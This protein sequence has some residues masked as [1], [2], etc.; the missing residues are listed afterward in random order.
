MH[1]HSALPQHQLPSEADQYIQAHLRHASCVKFTLRQLRQATPVSTHLQ[2]TPQSKKGKGRSW[3]T[4]AVH[5]LRHDANSTNT[6]TCRQAALS[7]GNSDTPCH[8]LQAACPLM[9]TTTLPSFPI[10]YHLV[11]PL[12]GGGGCRGAGRPR[13]HLARHVS[14]RQRRRNVQG[15]GQRQAQAPQRA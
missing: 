11:R 6:P 5:A 7:K 4:H 14:S 3:S 10:R 2:T 13:L 9:S 12:L 1:H 15:L 8:N